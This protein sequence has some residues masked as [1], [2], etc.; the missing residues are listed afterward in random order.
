MSLDED[1]VP[2]VLDPDEEVRRHLPQLSHPDAPPEGIN[3]LI[4]RY[5]RQPESQIVHPLRMYLERIRHCDD[6][7]QA[8]AGT[9]VPPQTSRHADSA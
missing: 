4:R 3:A 5:V 2:D 6:L 8:T 7:R 1:G 9:R